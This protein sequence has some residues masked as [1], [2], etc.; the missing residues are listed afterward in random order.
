MIPQ[1]QIGAFD[2]ALR[3]CDAQAFT[4]AVGDGF[5]TGSLSGTADS[6]KGIT[7]FWCKL[8]AADAAQQI[9][10]LS[11]S[12]STRLTIERSSTGLWRVTGKNSAGTTILLMPSTN[13]F[14]AGTGWKNILI[15]WDLAVGL[16]AS[17]MWVQD[18]Q[19]TLNSPTLT[20]DSINYTDA[21]TALVGCATAGGLGSEQ[22]E[23]ADIYLAYGQYL[24]F[25]IVSNRRKFISAS[26][27]P[28]HLGT[29]GSLPTGTAP[30]IYLHIDD[31]E[32]VN[33]F[34]T[35]RG[36]GGNFTVGGTPNTASTSPSD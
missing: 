14:L 36:S 3:V 8:I 11:S 22:F 27:K 7:S 13:T 32:S 10:F 20:N 24:D 35:N 34:A 17:T 23:L 16:T 29:T 26:G 28:V 1:V 6:K 15:S 31:G 33:N 18:T 9:V 5:L 19:Q 12:T 30:T 25:T 4:S 21:G 2:P